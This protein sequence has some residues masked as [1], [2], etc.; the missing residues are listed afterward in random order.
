MSEII[1]AAQHE[2]ELTDDIDADEVAVQLAALVLGQHILLR[3]TTSD[4]Q[5]AETI[6]QFLTSQARDTLD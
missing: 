1:S 6:T 2:G 3:S 4:E 5:I